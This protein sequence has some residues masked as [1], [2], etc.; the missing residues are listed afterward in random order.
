MSD[1]DYSQFFYKKKTGKESVKKQDTPIPVEPKKK[2]SKFFV[3]VVLLLCFGLV[4]FS[5][6]FFNN[7]YLIDTI[8]IAFKGNTYA[9]Y[10][11]VSE[12]SSRELAYAQSLL[13][14]QG[15]GSGYIWQEEDS[16]YVVYSLYVDK[17]TANAIASKNSR[18][19]VKDASYN[20]KNTEV[21]NL[22]NRIIEELS[23][24]CIDY[25]NGVITES[26]LLEMINTEKTEAYNL[27]DEL[28][29]SKE[30]TIILNLALDSLE[31][32]DVAST[33]KLNLLSDIR[34]VCSS[35][36]VNMEDYV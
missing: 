35:I 12:L 14:Q 10:M 16:Y 5:V 22:C 29:N 33:S 19:F 21:F 7:G 27:I 24:G 36:A 28:S 8:T 1:V 23:N 15:G 20:S 2:R 3:F 30:N 18:T 11:V 4:F 34:Y 31:E 13:V 9:Y 32:L 25:E 6:D 17:A 26:Q